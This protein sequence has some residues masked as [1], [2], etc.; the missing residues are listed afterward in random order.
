VW[1]VSYG[2]AT[3]VLTKLLLELQNRKPAPIYKNA[4]L[5]PGSKRFFDLPHRQWE[6]LQLR[7]NTQLTLFCE[8]TTQKFERTKAYTLCLTEGSKVYKVIKGLH[9]LWPVG[10]PK[11]KEFM[12]ICMMTEDLRSFD[13][14]R[15][16]QR[17]MEAEVSASCPQHASKWISTIEHVTNPVTEHTDA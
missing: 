12:G 7:Q 8:S 2:L 14:A 5:R 10:C 17:E 13:E 16:R 11:C 15:Q 1:V 4:V 6:K 3:V 9:G